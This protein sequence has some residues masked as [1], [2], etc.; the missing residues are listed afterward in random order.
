MNQTWNYKRTEQTQSVDKDY[1]M[2]IKALEKEVDLVLSNVFISVLC[3]QST[4][5]ITTTSHAIEQCLYVGSP[6]ST[7]HPNL[8]LNLNLAAWLTCAGIVP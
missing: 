8:V 7:L 3:D 1:Q 6:F 4:D 5:Q 2:T